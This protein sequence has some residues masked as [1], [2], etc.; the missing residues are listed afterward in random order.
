MQQLNSTA[1]QEKKNLRRVDRS[2]TPTKPSRMISEVIIAYSSIADHNKIRSPSL[3]PR[4]P[5]QS[6][7]SKQHQS[8]T[9]Q[10]ARYKS[11]QYQIESNPTR[12]HEDLANRKNV[13]AMQ[14]A[15]PHQIPRLVEVL[16]LGP[17]LGLRLGALR[18]PAPRRRRRLAGAT[19]TGVRS[20]SSALL[21]PG[22]RHLSR[23]GL[24][25]L[26][27][28]LDLDLGFGIYPFGGAGGDGFDL[29]EAAREIDAM[30]I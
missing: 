30:Q 11:H 7:H 26:G 15:R 8:S 5:P 22:T 21:A 14:E 25:G 18:W 6:S 27:F 2:Y 3:L 4:K 17:G 12:R 23:S 16:R 28:G 20:R 10:S 13:R 9:A 1:F 24:L 19:G 29:G